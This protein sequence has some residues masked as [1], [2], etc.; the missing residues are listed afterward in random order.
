MVRL[1]FRHENVE[2]YTVLMVKLE[3]PKKWGSTTFVPQKALLIT[4]PSPYLEI[5]IKQQARVVYAFTTWRES[6]IASIHTYPRTRRN[7][8]KISK[9]PPW[10][11]IG[12]QKV[13]K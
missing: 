4:M 12:R 8:V 11:Q 9:K 2:K 7:V 5:M 3:I 10:R 1:V 6:K 13:A